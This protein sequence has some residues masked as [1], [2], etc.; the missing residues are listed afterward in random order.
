MSDALAIIDLVE[1]D[2]TESLARELGAAYARR[3]KF[4]RTEYKLEAA[5]A[6]E[7]ANIRH[8]LEFRQRALTDPPEQVTYLAL[9]DIADLDPALAVAAWQRVKA[10]ARDDVMSGHRAAGAME[11]VGITS[12]WQRAQ[13]LAIRAAFVEEWQPANGGERLLVDMLAQAYTSYLA[14]LETLQVYT[15]AET[16]RQQHKLQ[17]SGSYES[18]RVTT[19]EAIEQA[20]AMVDRFN[21][22]FLRTLRQIRDLRRYTP[23]MVINNPGQVNIASQQVNTS[24]NGLC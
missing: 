8:D 14:W 18:P 24:G 2:E 23:P 7:R 20:A 13:F 3:I 21:R 9:E 1:H 16:S 12:A 19:Q 10:A 17:E 22:L 5:D 11:V 15:T 6:Q 4:Y